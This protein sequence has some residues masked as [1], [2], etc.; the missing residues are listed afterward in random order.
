[1]CAQSR[2]AGGVPRAGLAQTQ[3]C[4]ELSPPAGGGGGDGQPGYPQQLL[5]GC[6]GGG[7]GA[8]PG[9]IS[10]HSPELCATARRVPP[11]TPAPPRAPSLHG[12]PAAPGPCSQYP[13]L[14]C[15]RTRTPPP[16]Q[17]QS[18]GWGPPSQ[19][20]CGW[21][22]PRLRGGP[23]AAGVASGGGGGYPAALQTK[24]PPRAP[25][26]GRAARRSARDPR[27]VPPGAAGA[28]RMRTACGGSTGG[29]AHAAGA[30]AVAM[31]T[32]LP[33]AAVNE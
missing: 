15:G 2:A 32:G 6:T 30:R 26:P 4:T 25:P 7:R 16:P 17:T 11:Q 21:G 33:R 9:P 28:L 3:P 29:A 1:M 27:G 18:R 13:A 5:L 20:G 31:A 8:R 12:D 19:C 10:A 24:G 22:P 23:S 14:S